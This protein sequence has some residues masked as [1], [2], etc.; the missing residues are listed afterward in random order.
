MNKKKTGSWGEEK[1]VDFILEKGY[2]IIERNFSSQYGE[3]DIIAKQ[4]ESIVFIEVKVVGA[5]GREDLG[6][7]VGYRKQKHILETAQSYLALHADIQNCRLRCDVIAIFTAKDE[8]VHIE[9]AF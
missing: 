4:N 9:N 1:A 3:I 7:I 6:H 2:T 8:I 5:F